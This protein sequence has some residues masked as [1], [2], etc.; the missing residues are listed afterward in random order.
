[1]FSS[2]SNIYIIIENPLSLHTTPIPKFEIE[3]NI[4]REIYTET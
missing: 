1:M 4:L 3:L 2:I